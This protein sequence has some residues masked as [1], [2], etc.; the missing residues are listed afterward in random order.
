MKG[1][2]EWLFG[3]GNVPA[4]GIPG[5]WQL[6]DNVADAVGMVASLS[7]LGASIVTIYLTYESCH[8][9]SVRRV[10]LTSK[11]LLSFPRPIHPRP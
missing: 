11:A 3:F 6:F 4:T 1:D 2:I 8:F 9:A 10:F 5:M 7:R